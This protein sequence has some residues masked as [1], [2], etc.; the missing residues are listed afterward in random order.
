ML[1]APIIS[2]GKNKFRQNASIVILVVSQKII[3][4][5]ITSDNDYDTD[6]FDKNVRLITAC[7]A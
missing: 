7:Y 4:M 6:I 3:G 1:K 2:K 5:I